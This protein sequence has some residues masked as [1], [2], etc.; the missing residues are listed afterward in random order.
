MIE[1]FKEFTFE[2]AHSLPHLP[3]G[4]KCKRVH[5][6]S[7]QVTVYATGPVNADGMVVDY[8]EISR[9]WELLE[10]RLDHHFIN[11]IPGL[12]ISTSENLA[13]WIYSGMKLSIPQISKV[14]VKETATAGSIYTGE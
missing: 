11:D 6:H 1:V 9:A 8:A 5:G 13:R 12:E 4:H 10:S 2:A 3:E 7:Y 14:L